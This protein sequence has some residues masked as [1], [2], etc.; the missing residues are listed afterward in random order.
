M[1]G[2]ILDGFAGPGGWSVA[3]RRLG[4]TEVGIE[5]D[6]AACATRAAAGLATIRADITT[7]DVSRLA[8]KVTGQIHSPECTTFSQAGGRAGVAILAELSALIGDMFAQQPARAARRRAMAQVLRDT[9]WPPPKMRPSKYSKKYK[10]PVRLTREQRSAAIRRAVF[11]ASLVAEPARFIAAGNPEWVALEQVPE[12]LPLWQVYAAELRKRG[13]SVWCGKLNAV[14]YGVPQ[15]RKR[16]VLIASR[17]RRVSRPEA[18]H[19][20]PRKGMQLWGTPWVSMA[21]AL[22]FGA[23]GRPSPTVTAGGTKSGGAEPFGHRDRNSLESERDAGRWALRMDIQAKATLPRPVSEPAPTIQFAH[24]SNLAAWVLHTNRGQEPDETRQTTNPARPAPA[25]TGKSGGQWKFRNN[26]NNACERSLDEPVGP[27]FFGHRSNWAGWVRERPATT[28]C[29]RGELG[30]PGHKDW[31]PGGKSQFAQ[32]SVR[33]TVEEAAALQSFP[34]GYPWAGT[35]TRQF[36]QIGN[37][38][39]PLLAVA[40]LGAAAGIDW[41]PVAEAYSRDVYGETGA[42]A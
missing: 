21:E 19:Y 41:V 33:I 30:R 22:G 37:A 39:P 20:D 42:A 32:D 27:V 12:V 11:S 13:Y 7:F 16:A 5:L 40:V 2:I 8:G 6:P 17:V 23:T 31:S 15:I 4:L 10:N 29:G 38:V 28:V 26:N 36:E 35:Q 24:R 14:D 18:T 25:L 1:N 34:P 9:G 3:A